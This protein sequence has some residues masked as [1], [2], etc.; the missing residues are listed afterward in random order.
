[1]AKQS[2]RQY[3]EQF[4]REA[5]KLVEEQG[6]GVADVARSLGVHRSQ[7]E[8]WRERFGQC[9]SE[10]CLPETSRGIASTS[11]K[12]TTDSSL[13]KFRRAEKHHMSVDITGP[14]AIV[15]HAKF[16][17]PASAS[18][19]TR[20]HYHDCSLGESVRSDAR[21]TSASSVDYGR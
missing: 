3:T 8:R 4:K 6:R 2:R 20:P 11:R 15:V 1:M 16:T 9:S 21:Q 14:Q 13:S 7:I 12:S 17:T 19:S 18:Q 5:V 10:R